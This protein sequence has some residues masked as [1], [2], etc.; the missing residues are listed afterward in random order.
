MPTYDDL[1]RALTEQRKPCKVLVL[2][3][4]LEDIFHECRE[5]AETDTTRRA[6]LLEKFEHL[7]EASTELRDFR[8]K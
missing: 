4:P 7:I 2:P 5:P 1:V 6:A 3:R 8:Y